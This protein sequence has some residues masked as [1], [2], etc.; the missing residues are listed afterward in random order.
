MPV[1]V[2]LGQDNDDL[3]GGVDGGDNV[4]D[5]GFTDFEVPLVQA[6][7]ETRLGVLQE[8]NQLRDSIN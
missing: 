3:P 8:L 4:L 2:G 5:N 7:S 6:E 1:D